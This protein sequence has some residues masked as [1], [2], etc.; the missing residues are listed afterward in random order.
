MKTTLAFVALCSTAACIA[1]A[2]PIFAEMPTN[3]FPKSVSNLG[4]VVGTATTNGFRW[5]L[6]DGFTS[7]AGISITGISDDD[8]VM[9]SPTHGKWTASTNQW[10]APRG[11]Q[12]NQTPCPN[13]PC[14][15]YTQA[16]QSY[17]NSD[18]S[19][20]A[21]TAREAP[22]NDCHSRAVLW[23]SSGDTPAVFV[24]DGY[25]NGGM[26]ECTSYAYV[27]GLSAN[28]EV[29]WGIDE[30]QNINAVRAFVWHNGVKRSAFAGINVSSGGSNAQGRYLAGYSA[31]FSGVTFRGIY[32]TINLAHI[33]FPA[34]YW[35]N[36]MAET[37]MLVG[38]EFGANLGQG[39]AFI[40]LE[41]GQLLDLY[42]HLIANNVQGPIAG[43]TL[44]GVYAISRNGRYLAGFGQNAQGE[45]RTFRVDLQGLTCDTIDFNNDG[46]VFD[47]QDIDAFLSVYSEGPCVPETATC[48]DIDFNNDGSIFDPR[49]IDA[50]LSVYAEGPCF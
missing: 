14:I 47:P 32:D 41:S 22:P 4:T 39:R 50:F 49:D 34:N 19:I 10:Q 16:T 11:Y 6:S 29:V 48:N 43:W 13:P 2:Q 15:Y 23:N 42:D 46:S 35:P 20:I 31:T 33:N 45:S 1:H 37:S 21:G 7:Y 27:Q 24:S 18:G 17:C 30:N 26:V 38:G 44:R 25:L 5:R 8:Q 36:C 40:R 28:G 9:I 3:G 12:F